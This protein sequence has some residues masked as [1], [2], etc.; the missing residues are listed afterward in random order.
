MSMKCNIMKIEGFDTGNAI[1]VIRMSIG[2]ARCLT[3]GE[4]EINQWRQKNL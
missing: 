1:L 4:A 2:Q 3:L